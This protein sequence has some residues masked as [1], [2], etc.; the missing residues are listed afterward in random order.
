MGQ[1]P[2]LKNPKKLQEFLQDIEAWVKLDKE[3]Q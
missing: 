1:Y 3:V 2:S